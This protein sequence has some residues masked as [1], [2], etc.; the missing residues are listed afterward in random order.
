MTDRAR[1]VIQQCADI[2]GI[3][4][5]PGRITRRCLTSPMRDVHNYL[6]RRMGDLDMAVQVDAAGNLRG[7]W[8]PNQSQLKRLLIGSHL[9]TVP[10]AGAFDGVLGVV[11]ALEWVLLAREMKL[12]FPIDVVGFSEEEGVR[13]GLPFIGSRALAGTFDE[14]LLSLRDDR[15][16]SLDEA[17]RAFGL[18]PSEITNAGVSDDV[19][20]FVEVHIE[21]GPVLDDSKLSVAAV[22]CIVGQT[23]GTLSFVGQANHAGTT[24][25]R[26]RRDALTASA[27]FILRVEEFALREQHLTATV[28]RIAV[29]PNATNVI[30]G[31]VILSLDCRHPD[32]GNRTSAVDQLLVRAQDIAQRRKLAMHWSKQ[33][34]QPAVPMSEKLTAHMAAAIRAAGLPLKVMTSGAG[35]DA[36]I[37][38]TRMPA[39]MLFLRSPGGISHDPRE[40]VLV[41]DIEASLRVAHRFL[42]RLAAD[43]G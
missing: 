28:G 22:N 32:D 21:Q 33:L 2:A 30:P 26:L 13:F 19:L 31:T 36:M 38:A 3:T 43:V 15:D 5:E 41:E 23:R 40:S 6:R 27:E 4:E 17:L 34:D 24:P 18:N 1:R 29:E 16:T 14:S 20:G 7:I 35:H 25:M 8:S 10:D 42:E 37:M 12:P 11:I 39:T 9:D